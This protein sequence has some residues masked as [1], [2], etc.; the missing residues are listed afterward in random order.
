VAATYTKKPYF[1]PQKIG[2]L[3]KSWQRHRFPLSVLNRRAALRD[4]DHNLGQRPQKSLGS[5]G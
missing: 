3:P 2:L 4:S 1:A 5:K